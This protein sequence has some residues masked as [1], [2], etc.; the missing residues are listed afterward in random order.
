MENN[1]EELLNLKAGD[2]VIIKRNYETGRVDVV[3]KVSPALI[4]I[5]GATAGSYIRYRKSD[6]REHSKYSLGY[7][8][9]AWT[10][11][12]QDVIDLKEKANAL[13][14]LSFHFARKATN[15]PPQ[16]LSSAHATPA[17]KPP[18]GFNSLAPTSATS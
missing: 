1:H 2:K 16:K 17:K 14:K 6:G 13:N 5:E 15:S 3:A 8:I 12:R 10:Q 9:V 11:E 7:Y 18:T 4:F